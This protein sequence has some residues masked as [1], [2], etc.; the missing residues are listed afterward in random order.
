MSEKL[1][2]DSDAPYGNCFDAFDKF[3]HS[4]WYQELKIR[5]KLI[6]SQQK[7]VWTSKNKLKCLEI[8]NYFW[9]LINSHHQLCLKLCLRWNLNH[10][11]QWLSAE[12]YSPD[13]IPQEIQVHAQPQSLAS[14]V[15]GEFLKP[16]TAHAWMHLGPSTNLSKPAHFYVCQE[17]IS[18]KVQLCTLRT[19]MRVT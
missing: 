5:N 1:N 2:N 14:S 19:A 9:L 8:H 7:P 10:C 12:A 6:L 16:G 3:Q 4:L 15:L 17:H 11:W 13:A 18:Q